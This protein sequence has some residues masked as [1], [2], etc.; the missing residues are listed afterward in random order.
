[1]IWALIGS[2]LGARGAQT[3]TC[4]GL[5]NSGKGDRARWG[6]HMKGHK[7]GKEGGKELLG[8]EMRQWQHAKESELRPVEKWIFILKT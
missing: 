3:R 4:R 6:N 1:M 7:A 5:G 8:N 2:K